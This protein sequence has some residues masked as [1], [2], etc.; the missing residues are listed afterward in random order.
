AEF[1]AENNAVCGRLEAL[2]ACN[3]TRVVDCGSNVCTA[4][5]TCGGGDTPNQCGCTS[6]P[7]A[8]FCTRIGAQCE[9]A[10]GLDNCGRTRTEDCGACPGATEICVQNACFDDV[11]ADGVPDDMDNCPQNANMTQDDGDTDMVG[12]VC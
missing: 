1:C 10:T 5:E 2:D 9:T 4:P 8:A 12:D 6:E 7:V 11:D 3:A